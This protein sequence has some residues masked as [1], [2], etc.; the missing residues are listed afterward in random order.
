MHDS[1]ATVVTL[2]KG[3]S[4]YIFSVG[5]EKK[6]KKK[7]NERNVSLIQKLIHTYIHT[8]LP[9]ILREIFVV[10]ASLIKNFHPNATSTLTSQNQLSLSQHLNSRTFETWN[11]R[12]VLDL[13][14]QTF[15]LQM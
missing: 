12:N 9:I 11:S 3:F 5:G 8:S 1:Q 15:H 14:F 13:K 7:A 4:L 10:A 6:K 2:D